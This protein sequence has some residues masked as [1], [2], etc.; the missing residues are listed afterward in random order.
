MRFKKQ[1]CAG[2]ALVAACDEAENVGAGE[3]SRGHSCSS[4]KEAT[5]PTIAARKDAI[6]TL[7]MIGLKAILDVPTTKIHSGDMMSDK[8]TRTTEL[9]EGWQK[10]DAPRGKTWK[11]GKGGFGKP[12]TP[13]GRI[14]TL[15]KTPDIW[16][17][18]EYVLA[19]D[20]DVAELSLEVCHDEDFAVFIN[21]ALATQGS[22]HI[23][24]YRIY[25]IAAAARK[26]LKVGKNQIAV[27]C[28]Q[29]VG[30]QYIDVDFTTKKVP[31][32]SPQ[33]SPRQAV[34]VKPTRPEATE[35]YARKKT[36]QGSLLAVRQAFKADDIKV[37]TALGSA[38]AVEMWRDFPHQSDWLMQDS[39]GKMSN[40]VNGYRDGKN[41]LTNLL[42]TDRDASLERQ[43][44][45]NA[46][47]EQIDERG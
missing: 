32:V 42:K 15:W 44:I 17:R 14:H 18:G 28:H 7:G 2:C 13:G 20:Q 36:W 21:G 11:T 39:P 31:H 34:A 6:E 16:L 10:P 23:K 5:A 24:D 19:T 40:W 29:T 43:L 22:G 41:D 26:A 3:I 30:G 45:Q 25:P 47:H 8:E 12:N 35:K 4:W 1:S 27:Y 46:L 37:D 33:K 38:L 9:G